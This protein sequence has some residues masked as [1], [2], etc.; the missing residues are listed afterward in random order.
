MRK[1]CFGDASTYNN[2]HSTCVS[3]SDEYACKKAITP[4][5]LKRRS[6]GT[7]ETPYAIRSG[8]KYRL[9]FFGDP[10]EDQLH[11]VE[12]GS[13]HRMEYC[14][15]PGCL[16]CDEVKVGGDG[17]RRKNTPTRRYFIS[18]LDR[19]DGDKVKLVSV[20]PGLMRAL[21]NA[22]G[23]LNDPIL[24]ATVDVLLSGDLPPRYDVTLVHFVAGDSIPDGVVPIPYA[25]PTRHKFVPKSDG[26]TIVTFLDPKPKLNRHDLSKH[27][28]TFDL[29][30]VMET[31]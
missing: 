24:G 11:W 8:E 29:Q 15:G 12:K 9:R 21:N 20:T 2:R 14:N 28:S 18:A 5:P 1:R 13:M 23:D 25:R 7:S 22:S 31:L 4:Q 6:P 16:L 17:V 30:K 10:V 19:A 26:P 3:C 27:E